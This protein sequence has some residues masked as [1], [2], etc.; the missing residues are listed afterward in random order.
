MIKK[1]L[2][3]ALLM[4]MSTGA[5]AA[6]TIT[7]FQG[8]IKILNVGKLDRVAVGNGDLLSTTMLDNG[9][10]LLLAEGE[11]ETTLHLWYSDG[12]EEDMKVHIMPKDTNRIMTELLVL[13]EEVKGIKV[14]RVGERIFLSGQVTPD[15]QPIL[16]TV[17]AAYTDV[18]DLTKVTAPQPQMLAGALDKMI[19]MDVKI[20]E[21]NTN[22][23]EDLGIEWSN[24]IAGPAAGVVGTAVRNN[25]FR[26]G[27]ATSFTPNL[28]LGAT[29]LGFF[30]IATEI[31]SRLN[32]LVNNGDAVILAQPKLSARSG[33]EAEFLAGGEVPVPT[34]GSLGSS[35][36]EFKEFGISLNIS[37]VVDFM[38]N[39][40][41]KVSTEVSAIDQSIAV[42]GVPGFL[43]RKT[44][45]DVSM[46]DGQTLVLSGLVSQEL[47]Q[48][49]N[50]LSFLGD[51]PILGALFR[52]NSWRNRE[53]E[54]VIFVT[55]TVYDH[56]SE[57]NQRN[58]R[59][60]QELMD[61]FNERVT[62]KGYQILD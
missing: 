17:K 4:L 8:E 33:G 43:T 48:D 53:T 3:I 19:Y 28:T 31:S 6:E 58:I 16:E 56:D 40:V 5:M 22:R 12:K 30:G 11:G 60:S 21:F 1:L 50:K 24:P 61:K 49:V 57:T 34:T 59:R 41:A 35:N 47:G 52:S 46:R 18:M 42:Q 38:N 51:I 25:E 55:P 54:L 10:L 15:E 23:L 14:K 26:A 2:H 39:I 29:N 32:F 37:P 36:V 7:V 20:T 13:L 45:T 44:S 27:E 9:Q 62:R